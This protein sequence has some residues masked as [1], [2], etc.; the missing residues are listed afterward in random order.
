MIRT[1]ERIPTTGTATPA[2]L[3]PVDESGG[4]AWRALLLVLVICLARGAAA[5]GQASDP[6]PPREV[7]GV[8]ME[9]PASL[10]ERIQALREERAAIAEGDVFKAE[11]EALLDLQSEVLQKHLDLLRVEA[12]RRER[13]QSALAEG[14]LEAERLALAA[15]TRQLEEMDLSVEMRVLSDIEDLE[16]LQSTVTRELEGPMRSA[17]QQAAAAVENVQ[18]ARDEKARI[19]QLIVDVRARLEEVR[20]RLAL[21]EARLEN[22]ADDAPDLQILRRR[23]LAHEIG[24]YHYDRRLRSLENYSVQLD[25]FLEVVSVRSEIAEKKQGI[26]RL[27]YEAAQELLARRFAEQ[28]R[29]V[30][31]KIEQKQQEAEDADDEHERLFKYEEVRRLDIAARLPQLQAR[32]SELTARQAALGEEI[33]VETNRLSKLRSPAAVDGAPD[34]RLTNIEVGA[35][36]REIRKTEGRISYRQEIQAYRTQ[37]R[38]ARS[39]L[40]DARVRQSTFLAELDANRRLARSAFEATHAGGATPVADA[41]NDERRRWQELESSMKETLN[42]EVAALETVASLLE[43][44]ESRR[45]SLH[46]VRMDILFLLERQNLLMRSDRSFSWAD[47]RTA[48]RDIALLPS[49]LNEQLVNVFRYLRSDAVRPAFVIYLISI[50]GAAI[51]LLGLRRR[52]SMRAERLSTLDISS[53]PNRTAISV[54]YFVQA[55][56]FATMLLLVPYLATWILDL[57]VAVDDLLRR[58]AWILAIYWIAR[59]VHRELF[60]PEPRERGV[61]P[62]DP[63]PAKLFARGGSLLLYMALVSFLFQ[64]ALVQLAYPNESVIELIAFSHRLLTG[65]VLLFL[66]FRRSHVQQLLP[67]SDMFFARFLRS[68]ASLLHP[69]LLLLVPTLLFLDFRGYDLLAS[70]IV[71]FSLILVAAS[72]AGYIVFNALQYLLES[73]LLTPSATTDTEVDAERHAAVLDLARLSLMAAVVV[74]GAMTVVKLSGLRFEDFRELLEIPLPFQRPGAEHP[75]TVWRLLMAVVV[76]FLAFFVAGKVKLALRSLVL[77]RTGLDSGVQYT[78][79]TITGYCVAGIGMYLALGQLIALKNLGLLL[80]ALSVGIG[81]G[82][83]DIVSNFFSGL[84]LLFERPLKVGDVIQVGN[85]EGIVKTINI[86]STTIQTFD[87]VYILVPNREFVTQ[88]VVNFIHRDPKMRLQLPVGVAYGSDVQLVRKVLFEVAENYGRVLKRPGPD[89]R[90]AAFGESSLDF[91]LMVWIQDTADFNRILSDLHYAIEAAFQR[92]HISIPFPQRD[93]HLRSAEPIVLQRAARADTATSPDEVTPE[94]E[95]G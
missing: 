18:R 87:N 50:L 8:Q 92:H 1:L 90:F 94:S 65:L 3:G 72:V 81:L 46:E 13:V 37:E 22:A 91:I 36:L 44:V 40:A 28:A 61:L 20:S 19:P 30:A 95:E 79:T 23:K 41:W 48:L 86:R 32:R 21:A 38:E 56:F 10:E 15:T 5:S 80:A 49:Y 54:M 74:I 89:V 17:E 59:R 93:L 60:R 63:A 2:V 12:E 67:S 71:R 27:R 45:R 25:R 9:T 75:I 31:E 88:N 77:P 84:I 11:K 51:V 70:F 42:S 62:L 24:A 43:D 57:P 73:R 6:A 26:A 7:G 76:F 55:V 53:L 33:R 58:T 39:A 83:Q 78:I 34:Q 82:L 35:M 69:A 47:I 16:T 85:T 4:R 29:A 64:N 14:T 66:F 52:V 68:L